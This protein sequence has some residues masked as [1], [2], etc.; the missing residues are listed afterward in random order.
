MG[1]T[2]EP[3]A[4]SMVCLARCMARDLGY[5]SDMLLYIAMVLLRGVQIHHSY[6]FECLVQ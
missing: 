4:F 6:H 5:A 3:R 2:M 1:F